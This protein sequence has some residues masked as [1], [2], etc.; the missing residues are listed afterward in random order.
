MKAEK[1]LF[2]RE[3]GAQGRYVNH[4]KER[5]WDIE[6][7]QISNWGSVEIRESEHLLRLFEAVAATI[8][9]DESLRAHVDAGDTQGRACFLRSTFRELEEESRSGARYLMAVNKCDM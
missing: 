5:R 9:R 2:M 4:I 7:G 8:Q 1:H 3:K 6:W